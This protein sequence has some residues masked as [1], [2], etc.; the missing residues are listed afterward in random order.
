MKNSCKRKL[1]FRLVFTVLI[2]V[3]ISS[4]KAQPADSRPIIKY[5][6]NNY[7][8]ISQ[9]ACNTCPLIAGKP[10]HR[11]KPIPFPPTSAVNAI[12]GFNIDQVP[13]IAA[14]NFLGGGSPE[15][16]GL[17]K[18]VAGMTDKYARYF[19][20]KTDSLYFRSGAKGV[21]VSKSGTIFTSS[22]T[23]FPGVDFDFRNA[24]SGIFSF[25]S[26]PERLPIYN[27]TSNTKFNQSPAK[28]YSGENMI[29]NEETEVAYF[30]V[31]P[32]N[33]KII[34]ASLRNPLAPSV[35]SLARKNADGKWVL[36][37][38]LPYG[39]WGALT[40]DHDGN[41]Y[42][43]DPRNHVI[44]KAEFDNNGKSKSWKTIA[45]K[46]GTP[47]FVNDGDGEDARFNK[48]GGICVDEDGNIYVGDAGNNVIRKIDDDGEVTTYAGNKEGKAGNV[49]DKDWEDA[50][51]NGPTALAYNEITKT[52]YVVDA[53]NNLIREINDDRA[54]STLAGN[55]GSA[56]PIADPK[57]FAN[58]FYY[59]LAK[60]NMDPDEA[61][62]DNP[63]GIAID[64]SGLGLY[65]SDENYIKYVNTSETIFRITAAF[66]DPKANVAGLPVLPLGI[67]MNKNNGSFFGIP[68]VPWEPT[69]YTIS[70]TNHVVANSLLGIVPSGVIT[71]EVVD[72]P[73]VPDTIIDNRTISLN[74][75]P[76]TWNGQ[77][78]K[79]A[80]TAT[81]TLQSLDGCDSL[82]K[83]NLL[84]K[85][86]F[87]YNSEPY[88]FSLGQQINPIVPTTAG[89]KI[90]TF[91]ISPALP[92]GLALN[93][94]T[95]EISGTPLAY[96]TSQLLPAIGPK[97]ANQYPAPWSL[98]A[99]K[100]AD[101]T[102]VKISDSNQKAIFE[103]NT[104]FQSLQ[105]SGGL[106]T[107][108]KGAYTDFSGLGAI[109]M[110]S[111]THYSVRLSNT[112]SSQNTY[113]LHTNMG[114]LNFMNSY[115]VYIDYN[116]DGDFEDSGERVYI[117][118]APQRDAHAEVFNLNI[119][120]TAT[121]GVTKMRIYC[122]EGATAPASYVF[123][124]ANGKPYSI[125]RTT[126]QALSFY[127]F[128]NNIQALL[129]EQ[130]FHS[131]WLD[132][133]E[134]EDYNI[135]IQNPLTQLYVITGSNKVGSA[136]SGIKM[137]VNKPSTSSSNATICSTEL[138][139]TWN[140]LTFLQAGTQT[141]HLINIYG[142][143][144]AATLILT[145]K[146]A[147]SSVIAVAN[148]GPYT[149]Q[150]QVYTES[151]D[152]VVHVMNTVG[153]DSAIIFR[154]RQKFTASVINVEI[155]P[156]Q[157]PY[158]WNGVTFTTAGTKSARLTNAEGCDSTATLVLRVLYN[159]YYPAINILEINKPMQAVSPQIEGNYPGYNSSDG[160]N[161][162]PALP[163]GLQLNRITGV[164]S[165]TPTQLSPLQ[166]Y[167]VTLSQNGAKP[168]TFKLSVGVP[169]ASTTTINNCGPYTWNGVV[170]DKATTLTSRFV[171]QYGFDSTATLILSIRNPSATITRL[172]VNQSELPLTWNGI[173]IT[174]EGDKTIYLVNAAGC[175]SAV[176]V[177]VVVG[178]KVLYQ[179]PTVLLANK[180]IVPIAPQNT[181]GPI[182][183]VIGNVSTLIKTN[184]LSPVSI[185]L[186]A[187]YNSYVSDELHGVIY[188]INRRGIVS[189]VDG[190]GTTQAL[191]AIDKAGNIYAADRR[192]NRIVKK[193][194]AGIVTVLAT[195]S[196]PGGI[197]I[198]SAGNVYFS[199]GRYH[200]IRK[201]SGTGT[202]STLAGGPTAGY[203][204]G[205]GTAAKFNTPSGLSVDKAGNVYVADLLNNRIRKITATGD[206]TS[207]AGN[208]AATSVDGI[209]S[210]AGFNA[211]GDIAAD[212]QGNKYVV[213]NGSSK[214][215]KID[216]AGMVSTLA[217]TTAGYL[218]G[219]GP[220][221]KFNSPIG[222]TT[223]S[224]G[225]VYVA[226][227]A[228]AAI[229]QINAVNYTI[230]PSLVKGLL[231]DHATGIISGTPTD[232]LLQPVTY[233]IHGYNKAGADSIKMVLAVCNPV[234]TSLT[235]DTCDH[236]V[237]NDST[238]RSSTTH[239]RY[240]KN[241]GGCDSV[242]TLHLIIR[243]GSTGPT[244]TATACESY[245]WKGVTYD[246][247]GVYTKMYPNAVGCDS[248][249]YLNL[250]IKAISTNNLFVDINPLQL[251]YTWRGKIFT[252]PGTQSIVLQ[253]SVGC[254]SIL[255]MT[256][257]ISN[258]LPNITYAVKDTILYWEKRIEVPIAMTNTGT[259][260]PATKIAERD[261]LVKFSPL[262]INGYIRHIVKGP[263]GNYYA[264][265]DNS[266]QI[267]ILSKSRGWTVF[268]GTGG[269]G[270]VDGP[271]ATAQFGLPRG[272]GFD[273]NGNLF[274]ATYMDGRLRKITPDGLVSTINTS[275]RVLGTDPNIAF[276]DM[277]AP[278]AL[279]V[280]ANN[281]VIVQSQRRITKFNFSTNQFLK[282]DMDYTPYFNGGEL[283]MKT[284]T[285]GNIY[286]LPNSGSNIVK[287]RPNGQTSSIGQRSSAY[288]YFKAGNGPDAFLPWVSRMA[289][290]L[291]NDNLYLMAFGQLL[292]VDTSENVNAVTG[293]WFTQN[294]DQIIS[295]DSGQVAI[296]KNLS[297]ILYNAHVYGVGSLPF[298]DN[299]GGKELP[300]NGPKIDFNSFDQRIR[301][302]STG[303][304]VGTPRANQ[305]INGNIY[306]DNRSTG[307]S[308][309]AAN[310]YGVSNFNMVITN[311][312]ITN[313]PE[314]FVTT[315]FPFLWR[316][317]SFN[318]P[319]DTA[320]YF[321][322]N[323]T[324]ANDT[325]YHL[326]LVYEGPPEPGITVTGNCAGGG[327]TLSANNAAKNA[328]SF[329]G[330][331]RATITNLRYGIGIPFFYTNPYIKPSG[332]YGINPSSAYEVWVKP[333]SVSGTQYFFTRGTNQSIGTFIGLSIQNG[334]FVYEFTQSNPVLAPYKLISNSTILPNV[335]THLAASYYDSALHVFINGQLE[336]ALQTPNSNFAAIGYD[337][338]TNSNLY[339]D[340]FL[341]GLGGQ[342]GF[343][344]EMDELRVWNT[345]RNATAIQA[346][347]NTSVAPMSSGLHLYYRFDGDLSDIAADISSSH[348][349]ARFIK[350]ATSVSPSKAPINF[351][352]YKWMPGSATTKS[353][354]V[355]Q[356]SNT[357]YTLTVTDY[358]GTAGSG[359]LMVSPL[360]SNTIETIRVCASSYNWHG[361]TYTASTS[362]PTW[363][364]QNQFG[365]DS[366]VTLHLTLNSL[367]AP[368]ITGANKIC[369]GST[370]TLSAAGFTS[371]VWLPNG[372]TTA[373]ITVQPNTTSTY[374]LKVTNANGCQA[375]VSKTV[376]VSVPTSFTE[377]ISACGS[378]TW[379]GTNYISSNNTATW[380]G[381][382]AA[383]CDS[384]VTLDLRI[385]PLPASGIVS[386]NGEANCSGNPLQITS[387]ASGKQLLLDGNSRVVA[388]AMGVAPS[389]GFT[390]E[391]WV[392]FS[393]IGTP[394]SIISQTIGS[395]PLPFDAGL[396]ANGTVSFAVG[397]GVSTST[398]S[399]TTTLTAKS[400]HH[401]AFV[402]NNKTI[403]IYID[404]VSS[405]SGVAIVPVAGK[406]N[407]FMIGNNQ[408]LSKPMVGAVDEIRVWNVALS[409]VGLSGNMNLS[410]K[411]GSNGLVAYYKFDEGD[412]ELP[413][414]TANGATT[415]TIVGNAKHSISTAPMVYQSYTWTG[416]LTSPVITAVNPGTLYNVMV[417]D[418]NGCSAAVSGKAV[419]ST[420]STFTEVVK[421]CGPY[422]WH[423]V[424]YTSSNSTAKWTTQNAAGCDSVVTL[425]LNIGT[426]SASTETAVACNYFIW[427]G[428]TYTKSVTNATWHTVNASGCDSVVTLQLTIT[429]TVERTD[430]VTVCGT[431]RWHDSTYTAST[432]A[433]VWYGISKNGCDSIVHL[434]L[435]IA[436]FP[437]AKINAMNRAADICQGK[438]LVL[439]N[440][441]QAYTKYAAGVNSFSSELT[442]N[443]NRQVLGA[444]N[445]YPNYGDYATAWSTKD[446][447][448]RP[449]FIELTFDN[450][451]PINFIDIY[452]TLNS[453]TIDT[454]YVKN[455][456]TNGFEVVYS[457]TAELYSK[458]LINRITFP[459]TAY[460]V[461]TI[462][463]AINSVD[464]PAQKSIDAVSIGIANTDKY[465]WSDGSTADTLDVSN[466]GKYVLTATNEFGCSVSDTINLGIFELQ[467]STGS[468]V[469]ASAN[470]TVSKNVVV[471]ASTIFEKDCEL[472]ASLQPTGGALAV[473]GA[474]TGKVWL[475]PTMP[476]LNGRP[477][478]KRHYEITPQNNAGNATGVITL[479]YTQ[480]D[481]D[482]LN[483]SPFN[484]GL[485][486][487]PDDEAGKQHFA[488]YQYSGISRDGTGL[489]GTY[490]QPGVLITVPAITLVWDDVNRYWKASFA[491]T[492]FGG[493]F[494]GNNGNTPLSIKDLLLFGVVKAGNSGIINWQ[495]IVGHQ[496]NSFVVEKSYDGNRFTPLGTVA[497]K[498]GTTNYQAIDQSL[499]TG[500]QYYRLKLLEKDG[501]I[502]Y[503][504]VKTLQVNRNEVFVVAPNPTK[505]RFTIDLQ[506]EGQLNAMAQIQLQDVAGKIIY[507]QK[508]HMNAGVLNQSVNI[509]AS[510]A[511]GIY[512]VRII[513]EGK[514][515][516]AKL[517]FEK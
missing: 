490:A 264:T 384:L 296:V 69:T 368:V 360:A 349:D 98:K 21:A 451:Q 285:K 476:S 494:A 179:S 174:K 10:L 67:S 357:L 505:G 257:R 123:Y 373:S 129:P 334:K 254:D 429:N 466:P 471:G 29:N 502:V 362:T 446:D 366:I 132:Y 244:T 351:T 370:A 305:I 411:P 496:V 353:I 13:G 46:F 458:P 171:N 263:D 460:A 37:R 316:G 292:R 163:N 424:T 203:A 506:V 407:N 320:T 187:Q 312:T 41:L 365:C 432:K 142:A 205:N 128:L 28:L 146:Q 331:N 68:I 127:P 422:T 508:A 356:A 437:M 345:V 153:C 216:T 283:D 371:Y 402:Y 249:I 235:L 213:D 501:S 279:S 514:T 104:A 448:L 318:A 399:T 229:R 361:T 197:A 55:A 390:L 287:I 156:N 215:R 449:E 103:N 170:Y 374:T 16:K 44:V 313:I 311:K 473:S 208:G 87:N 49:D 436:N 464:V 200:R 319:T 388:D 17:V 405:A 480:A 114:L 333:T 394:Q 450:P 20:Q 326:H 338:G 166:T 461:S 212:N 260:V 297:G 45:G 91:S 93:A 298:M 14:P 121:S 268:A 247:T 397:N 26:T 5:L 236:Y 252:V 478:L 392:N 308:I 266:N 120:V 226:D 165:G 265:A 468:M 303:A 138:P 309:V 253:N 18:G 379:H 1:K 22:S 459:L 81:A 196:S 487:A 11:Y 426:P 442:Q 507:T 401:V 54:V 504:A 327:I 70:V 186:D 335:W 342:F 474:V 369:I 144:S 452:E 78:L 59:I 158:T 176:T 162:S 63:T 341:G 330:T 325:L 344:G 73:E 416:G 278:N 403:S 119:P 110:F 137:A 516:Q 488:I 337:P 47:G 439:H 48:P 88:I 218:D 77:V 164:I 359:S 250:T 262:A 336:G 486:T 38:P 51:F 188:K 2:F 65:V 443:V 9:A 431:Y 34:Y 413:V 491:T 183:S 428:N 102:Q 228:N 492:G 43:A 329:D 113:S 71:F 498:A 273:S 227:K 512:L 310:H 168:S 517:M 207:F 220:Q 90:D 261:T 136:Q 323:K 295:A 23:I 284:D 237:W 485:P 189:T 8:S 40:V 440:A 173:N 64:P 109:K 242:V 194:I 185:A 306:A 177:N 210:N 4:L 274:V 83:L 415:A 31:D 107:G 155:L 157:L 101:L 52:L 234:A 82:V 372:E 434:D 241:K 238:Y 348:R 400:W 221:A 472:I 290:D 350:P 201:I 286:I 140:G 511:N 410:V 178:P 126:E 117:S 304:I 108:T 148:C 499:Q 324:G 251:P 181:G 204:N 160:Y 328:I 130:I 112:L 332:G 100:G 314:N 497:G 395:T 445:T 367:P 385:N 363:K 255:S 339:P 198:D 125:R 462:R 282:M 145:V 322:T 430:T 382:N 75:L 116:R 275:P 19:R 281:N 358:K 97:T 377:K 381:V 105:G 111:N 27:S 364:G 159:I 412:S 94:Q 118:A 42:I 99:D 414:N 463:I 423:G 454:V 378:Y 404:G 152:Y 96:A 396:N 53:K 510:A 151:G 154:F 209:T 239:T 230:R 465:K 190:F 277:Y 25:N 315:R 60:L 182:P 420:P 172:F 191:L 386:A 288:N 417:T 61:K 479:Y 199:E 33:E 421:A 72:C 418:V 169:S 453:G 456:A 224:H 352:S 433:P 438:G 340:F 515:Y 425:N 503:S 299:Y 495:V 509:P 477:Y 246:K 346:T 447:Q 380:V 206:V 135:E 133:G 409:Q 467:Q 383:G 482:E 57:G 355:N 92:A 36:I 393:S 389:T 258:L 225:Q 347:L 317:R 217:G 302:D 256:V 80:G 134:F 192:S 289:I 193:D 300:Y 222:I 66:G 267:F 489:P 89:S 376:V 56:N 122:V 269:G 184:Y 291:S 202:V 427:H 280:D 180:P 232:T 124:D 211:P 272:L 408:S 141:A 149:Y 483:A 387:R 15:I 469:I 513:I 493:F 106:G 50:K 175:D 301:L 32:N 294:D 74:Q 475:E 470:R 293:R 195:A 233:T 167:T 150:G 24:R 147:T 240:L 321:A 58:N 139:Y 3:S 444:P 161:I 343:D 435:T 6:I 259:P 481:F 7:A 219:A 35:V 62:F 307:Y 270:S 85:P 79:G 86:E 245:V 441:N 248:T 131:N 484:G 143:D 12:P 354:V 214:I 30:A 95:G 76:F 243:K 391:G 39:V 231:F 375:T 457:G 419:A 84:L 115:A 276:A 500:L 406:L 271:K 455:P 223:D 398:I